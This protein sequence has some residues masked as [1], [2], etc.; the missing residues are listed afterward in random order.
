LS[1]P[2]NLEIEY[3]YL[4]RY[5]DIA[6]LESQPG[7]KK[8]DIVQTYLLS[9]NGVT[10]RV[11]SWTENGTTRFF[12]TEKKRISRMAAEENETQIS[13]EEYLTLLKKADPVRKPIAKTRY[14]ISYASHLLEI[15][16]YP[17]WK[18]QAVLEIE[19]SQEDEAVDIPSY[20]SVLRDVTGE[21][22]YKNQSFALSVPQED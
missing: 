17:F 7:S 11:R 19:I 18:K 20:L 16:I 13:E 4:I 3:K 6:V 8:A 15:D 12:K 14:R 22:K 5:P 21:R 10:A 9:E 2:D 1:A